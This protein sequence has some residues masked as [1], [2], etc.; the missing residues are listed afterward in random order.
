MDTLIE[1]AVRYIGPGDV[2]RLVSRVEDGEVFVGVEDSGPGF[3]AAALA[4]LSAAE[5]GGTDLA[6]PLD[7]RSQ[8]GLGLGLVREAIAIRG[9]HL[10]VGRSPEDGAQVLMAAPVVGWVDGEAEPVDVV[11]VARVTELAAAAPS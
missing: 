1:N 5:P 3:G 7:A 10:V 9:G 8:T 11:A 4:A 6:L 2:V